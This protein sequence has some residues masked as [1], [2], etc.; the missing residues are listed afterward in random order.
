MLMD[1]RRAISEIASETITQIERSP[2]LAGHP[3]DDQAFGSDL[4]F[5]KAGGALGD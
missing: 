4:H 5:G 2:L 1:A 3:L